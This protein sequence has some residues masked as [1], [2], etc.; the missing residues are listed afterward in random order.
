MM[1]P[2]KSKPHVLTAELVWRSASCLPAQHK[3]MESH[4]LDDKLKLTLNS[5]FNWKTHNARDSFAVTCFY[6]PVSQSHSRQ[7]LS[8][9]PVRTFFVSPEEC[10]LRIEGNS[11][12]DSKSHE[13]STDI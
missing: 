2:L 7:L 9:E 10:E 13:R 6:L 4:S 12:A 5:S 8:A 3:E 11:A 1:L